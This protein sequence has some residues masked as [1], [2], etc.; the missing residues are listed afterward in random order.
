MAGNDNVVREIHGG[1]E[2]V[3]S[4]GISI[5]LGTS[6]DDIVQLLGAP[7]ASRTGDYC[8]FEVDEFGEF[9]PHPLSPGPVELSYLFPATECRIFFFEGPFAS[10]FSLRISPNAS[11]V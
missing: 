10:R 6:H 5:S 8:T 1:S 9:V 3:T 2:L 11:T 4:D 7:T